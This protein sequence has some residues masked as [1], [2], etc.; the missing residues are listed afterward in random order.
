MAYLGQYGDA[1]LV[2]W[3]GPRPKIMLEEV[4]A[5]VYKS[6]K[7]KWESR[8]LYEVKIIILMNLLNTRMTAKIF[9]F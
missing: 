7:N 2:R 8:K 5:G 1:G 9:I 3:N 6:D 4:F